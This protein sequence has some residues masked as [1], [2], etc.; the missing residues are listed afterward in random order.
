[1]LLPFALS[2][3]AQ[4]YEFP[5]V[6]EVAMNALRGENAF[7]FITVGHES[8]LE[9]AKATLSCIQ[10]PSLKPLQTRVVVVDD[11]RLSG[12]ESN[13][14][15]SAAIKILPV[16]STHIAV[17]EDIL[18]RSPA[19]S[20]IHVFESSWNTLERA[21]S[22]FGDNIPRGTGIAQ[23]IV[24]QDKKLSLNF[25]SWSSLTP[26]NHPSSDDVESVGVASLGDQKQQ[27]EALMNVWTNLVSEGEFFE[28][29]SSARMVGLS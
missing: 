11:E 4:K 19:G 23:T 1:M 22:L 18:R 16:A 13:D 25:P 21:I 29:L 27:N 5:K 7:L 17:Y 6:N 2:W 12:C 8:D 10:T 3:L 28:L 20:T 24:G 15:S 14:S 26:Q 9:L